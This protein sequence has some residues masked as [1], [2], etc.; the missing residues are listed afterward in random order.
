MSKYF[1]FI[2]GQ[3]F[4]YLFKKHPNEGWYIFCLGENA[5][6]VVYKKTYGRDSNSSPSWGVIVYGDSCNNKIPTNVEGFKSRSYAVDYILKSHELTRESYNT[7]LR[8]K[9]M[10][11][12]GDCDEEH[13]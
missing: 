12:G 10:F 9:L 1:A 8:D 6:G 2:K 7:T 3:P 5:L 13:Y 11:N 4:D